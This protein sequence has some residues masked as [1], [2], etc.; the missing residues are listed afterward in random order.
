MRFMIY[1]GF[2]ATQSLGE[3]QEQ[4]GYILTATSRLLVK[5]NPKTMSSVVLSMVD[6]FMVSPLH[7]LSTCFQ[8]SESTPFMAAHGMKLWNVLEQNPD[9]GKNFHDA[10]ANDSHVLMSV[11][12]N[13]GKGVFDNLKSLVDVGG[14]TGTTA[15][16]VVRAFPH[17]HCMVLDLP[18]VVANLQGTDNVVFIGSDMFE[19]I[20]RADAVLLKVLLRLLV[21]HCLGI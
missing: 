11:I 15:H 17:L 20:P 9:F 4:E 19:C 10:M 2:F 8:G 18:N 14:G 6:P 12:L 1:L 7:T 3:N 5:A 16:A 21:T 13:E